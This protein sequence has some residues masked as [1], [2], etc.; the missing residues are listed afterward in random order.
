M[1]LCPCY[2][3]FTMVPNVYLY[4]KQ[5]LSK[6]TT[7]RMTVTLVPMRQCCQHITPLTLA[8]STLFRETAYILDLVLQCG[9]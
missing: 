9:T 6:Y 8:P 4:I 5:I 1:S 7:H 3:S 2:Y